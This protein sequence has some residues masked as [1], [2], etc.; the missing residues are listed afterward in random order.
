[1]VEINLVKR[2]RIGTIQ[3][4]LRRAYKRLKNDINLNENDVEFSEKVFNVNTSICEL[5]FW[6]IANNDWHNEYN[7]E[8]LKEMKKEYEEGA[9]K[10]YGLRHAYNASK[11]NM[12][13]VHLF[14]FEGTK[15]FI[16][17]LDIMDA[18]TPVIW[19]DCPNDENYPVQ[20]KNY[21]KYLKGEEVIPTFEKAITFLNVVNNK[22]LFR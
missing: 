8:I 12:N 14:G 17:A 5:L 6:V 22:V 19:I 2:L 16:E 18:T 21:R 3:N 10:L 1:M 20:V 7:K 4:G 11:H 13:F 9:N 15:K